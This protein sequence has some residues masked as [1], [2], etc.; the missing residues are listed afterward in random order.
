MKQMIPGILP[1]TRSLIKNVVQ[2]GD[3]VVDATMG[4]GLDTLFLAQL[5]GVQ[6]TVLAYD[7]Q[8]TALIKTTARLETQ[9]ALTQVR[10]LHKGHEQVAEELSQL[11]TP[12][13]AAMFNLGYLPGSDKSVVTKPNTTLTA[14]THLS[15]ALKPGGIITL[16]IYSGHEE[17]M[18]EKNILLENLI[19]WDQ[20]S[21]NILQYAFINQDNHPPFLIAIE[22]RD[23]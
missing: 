4:N 10:L 19:T 9:Q 6:G 23:R 16:V 13:A 17:G 8:E 12:I 1:F 18:I 14:L 3:I 21:Y 20:K 22:K 15:T 7:V 5:V 11:D 2:P